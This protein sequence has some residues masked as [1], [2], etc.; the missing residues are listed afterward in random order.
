MDPVAFLLKFIGT[1]ARIGAIITLTALG[2]GI[3]VQSEIQP[4]ATLAGTTLYQM[5]IV[6]GMIGL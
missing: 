1:T 4:F 6:A 5:M 2:L 3:L